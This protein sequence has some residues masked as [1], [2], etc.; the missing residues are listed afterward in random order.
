MLLNESCTET[1]TKQTA[2][3]QDIEMEESESDVEIVEGPS[4]RMARA[5][6]KGKG[7]AMN[8]WQD[9]VSVMRWRG[10][11]CEELEE[12]NRRLIEEVRMYKARLMDRDEEV[13]EL[14]NDVEGWMKAVKKQQGYLDWSCSR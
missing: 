14:K 10:E 2:S 13:E 6:E 11:E 9:E 1:S 7:K 5:E 8:D 12:M 4:V 3:C